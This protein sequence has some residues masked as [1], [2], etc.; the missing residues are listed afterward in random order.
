MPSIPLRFKVRGNRGR[1][2]VKKER[3]KEAGR[4][5]RIKI[6]RERKRLE[7]AREQREEE[8]ETKGRL[9]VSS[10]NINTGTNFTRGRKQV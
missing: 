7:R 4:A 8:Y 9:E 2:T 10:S 6:R 1:K 5:E 3:R